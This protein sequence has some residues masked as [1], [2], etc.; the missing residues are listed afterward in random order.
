LGAAKKN[1]KQLEDGT[2]HPADLMAHKLQEHIEQ[3]NRKAL[4]FIDP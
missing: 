1:I 2:Y 3:E 4:T